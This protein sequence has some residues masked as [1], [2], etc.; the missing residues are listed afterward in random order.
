MESPI[1]YDV[2]ATGKQKQW[3][4][5]VVASGTSAVIET[6]FGQTGG[7][8]QKRFKTISEGK[9]VG[10]KNETTALQQAISEAT[11]TMNKKKASG[12]VEHLSSAGQ[13]VDADENTSTT[14]TT[15]LTAFSDSKPPLPMLA[16]EFEKR[17]HDIKV[18]FFIQPKVDGVR[19]V[20]Y[21]GKLWSRNGK[22]FP[23]LEHI[24]DKIK[25]IDLTLDGELYANPEDIPFQKLVGLVKKSKYTGQELEDIKKI[26][27]IVYDCI[28]NLDF[29]KRH[30]LLKNTVKNI[31]GVR[32]LDTWICN[33]KDQVQDYL[34]SCLEANWEGIMLRNGKGGYQTKVRSKNLQK[35]KVFATDEFEIVGF[36][37]GTGSDEGTIIFV[38]KTPESKTFSVRPVGT[39]ED[40][41]DMFKNGKTFI[42]KQLTVKYQNLIE[43]S[44]VPRFP[45]GLC[46]REYE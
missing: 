26:Q 19:A 27:Y 39:R 10:K 13:N 33:S 25:H 30:E 18:P 15:E 44:N 1:L 21:G 6:I 12:Y 29:D 31:D 38:C 11:S 8:L 42:G 4:I 35:L 14:S 3:Q 34:T 2:G 20:L 22:E 43:G 5:K 9:N 40:R 32:L 16:L 17:G 46:V 24:L 36:E 7:T 45:V 37:Q 28:T 41:A 23:G